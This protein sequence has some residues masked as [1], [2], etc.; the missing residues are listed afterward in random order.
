MR[1]DKHLLDI[2][3]H[4]LQFSKQQKACN[5]NTNNNKRQQQDDNNQQ[6]IPERMMKLINGETD[7][8]YELAANLEKLQQQ[9]QL[10]EQTNE[11]Q[12][13]TTGNS[14]QQDAINVVG[15][16]VQR[17]RAG[18]PFDLTKAHISS[19]L[20]GRRITEPPSS[21]MSLGGFIKKNE[22]QRMTF[23]HFG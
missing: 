22:P 18:E 13:Q 8:S 16:S 2:V 12:E 20:F 17:P 10:G 4:L 7:S 11:Q 3:E 1:R 19:L 21:L 23:M 14:E 6:E 5:T 9:Q 15:R